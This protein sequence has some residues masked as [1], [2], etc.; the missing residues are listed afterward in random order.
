MQ[1]AQVY[2]LS[3]WASRHLKRRLPPSKTQAFFKGQ[4]Q[5]LCLSSVLNFQGSLASWFLK[6]SRVENTRKILLSFISDGN[7][8]WW[9]WSVKIK[10]TVMRLRARVHITVPLT[11]LPLCVWSSSFS[12]DGGRNILYLLIPR[13]RFFQKH[14]TCQEKVAFV[15]VCAGKKEKWKELFSWLAVVSEIPLDISYIL[16]STL[17][18]KDI[19]LLA[20]QHFYY[21]MKLSDDS[22]TAVI[23]TQCLFRGGF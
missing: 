18:R 13:S 23:R 2:L 12:C 9:V 4:V 19:F 6:V 8:P 22:L 11:K 5:A 21:F 16:Q 14:Q 15:F 3:C 7:F 1:E 10:Y 17:H 20:E